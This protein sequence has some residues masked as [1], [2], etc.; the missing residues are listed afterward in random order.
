MMENNQ[1]CQNAQRFR[2]VRVEENREKKNTDKP[3][4]IIYKR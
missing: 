4:H 1:K 2:K 3:M